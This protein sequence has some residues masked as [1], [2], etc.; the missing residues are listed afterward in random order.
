ARRLPKDQKL[1]SAITYLFDELHYA[2]VAEF[3]YD[4]VEPIPP[5]SSQAFGE[6]HRASLQAFL[7]GRM[8]VKSVELVVRMFNHRYSFPSTRCKDYVE[9]RS[10]SYSLSI[11]SLST[12]KYA[13]CSLSSWATQI[14][15]NRVYRDM[16]DL[17]HPKPNDN[18][19][20]FINP[21]LVTSANMR[22]KAK[23]VKTVTKDDLLS[24][25][26]S[27]HVHFFKDRVP[28]I[29]YLTECMAAPRM[30]SLLITCKRRP[31]SIVSALTRYNSFLLTSVF[32]RFKLPLYHH[33]SL[34][35]TSM[36]TAT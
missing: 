31:P 26:I 23:G 5:G 32:S 17:I 35:K 7:Q 27:D 36:L 9:E 21:R 10:K 11:L 28:L 33:L 4:F 13:R 25:K 34:H 14:V 1:N 12:I 18:K 2:S 20:I 16:K 3:F 6:R 29:W 24:F 8:K 19:P 22:T 30:N 15:G